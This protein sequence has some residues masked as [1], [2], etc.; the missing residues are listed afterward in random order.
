M[1]KQYQRQN[2]PQIPQMNADTSRRTPIYNLNMQISWITPQLGIG[3]AIWSE[4]RM[5]A[6]VREGVTHILNMQLEFDD[7][8]LA[9]VYDV[10]VCWVGID[11]DYQHKPHHVLM[12]GLDFAL[13]ALESPETKLY[14]HCAA[15]I[16]RAPM[17]ALA[18]LHAQ[19]VELDVAKDMIIRIRPIVDFLPVYVKSVADLIK[20]RNGKH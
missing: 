18:V 15:G 5:I 17:M 9:R 6:L 19:G 1:E 20:Q 13:Q 2:P 7:R 3:G 12:P 8:P 11:D 14:I 4:E 16:H 10:P